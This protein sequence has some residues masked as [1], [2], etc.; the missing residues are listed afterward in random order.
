[1]PSIK[2]TF[3]DVAQ[4]VKF[5]L[6]FSVTLSCSLTFLI[7]SKILIERKEL[8]SID[9]RNWAILTIGGFLITAASSCLNEVIE[10]KLDRLMNRTK[11][12]P[13]PTGRFRNGQGLVIGMLLG[14]VGIH[15]LSLLSFEIGLLSLLSIV[16]YVAVYT[17]M[18]PHSGLN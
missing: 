10:V 15:L 5:R 7:A 1:M 6:S 8:I 9:W 12:R 13:M 3:S 11:N 4:L 16:L 14:I 2:E 18:K 17:P